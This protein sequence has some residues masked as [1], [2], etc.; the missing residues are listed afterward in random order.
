MPRSFP[1][2][3]LT[4]FLF[5]LCGIAQN[6][7]TKGW[8]FVSHS[9]KVSG[10]WDALVDAQLRSED[11]FEF[12]NTLL[13]RA[14]VSY[15]LSA[16]HST[17]LGYAYKGDW[18]HE[19]GTTTQTNENR[20]Y[21]QYLYNNTFGKAEFTA[22]AR[23]EQRFIKDEGEH[24]QFAQRAR[25]FLALQIPIVANADFSRGLYLNFQDE[26]FVNIQHKERVNND[27]FDQNRLLGSVGYRW[28]K[29][30]DTEIGY[31]FW[32]QSKAEDYL[33][34]NVIQLMVTTSF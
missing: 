21:E 28:S 13:L 10:S 16:A 32:R 29:K 25:A 20:I 15:N 8:I 19:D 18:N 27:F 26:V 11:K 2:L 12:A 31:M 33:S 7:E 17:A 4:A 22:R 6:A 5:P 23:V 34:S 9:Q 1:L 3:Y 30:I 24:V 14:A